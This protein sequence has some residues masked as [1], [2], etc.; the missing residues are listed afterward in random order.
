MANVVF[1]LRAFWRSIST[2]ER[3]SAD[4][5]LSDF[6]SLTLIF[7]DFCSDSSGFRFFF[8]LILNL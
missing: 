4:L 7:A 2:S 8:L 6:H 3:F 1:K 5:I